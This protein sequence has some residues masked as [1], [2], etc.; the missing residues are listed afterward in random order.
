MC[1]RDSSSS[2]C[3]L[4]AMCEGTFIDGASFDVAQPDGRFGACQFET[5]AAA[6]GDGTSADGLRATV[7]AF[8]IRRPTAR[9]QYGARTIAIAEL[10]QQLRAA[11]AERLAL[12][13]E[14]E[15]E[16]AAIPGAVTPQAG[17]SR[18]RGAAPPRRSTGTLRRALKSCRPEGGVLRVSI[19]RLACIL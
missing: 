6:Q 5:I 13:A 18:E 1:I 8:M 10:T 14:Y 7:T 16:F 17:S 2:G 11:Q 4:D 12:A 9:V 15:A 19:T 3:T